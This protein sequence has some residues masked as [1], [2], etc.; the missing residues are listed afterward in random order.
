MQAKK[1]ILTVVT[2]LFMIF[3]SA[4]IVNFLPATFKGKV[5]DSK[6]GKPVD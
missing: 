2:V 5:V 1:V 4:E 3:T 6:T